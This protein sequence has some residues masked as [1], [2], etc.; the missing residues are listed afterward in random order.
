MRVS[1]RAPAA[2]TG[3]WSTNFSLRRRY[4]QAF[5]SLICNLKFFTYAP[6]STLRLSQPGKLEV[7]PLHACCSACAPPGDGL[8]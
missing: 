6:D 5:L 1:R 8:L 3:V 7:C 2:A 4:T